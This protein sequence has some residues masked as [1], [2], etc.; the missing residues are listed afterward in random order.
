MSKQYD[1]YILASTTQVLYVGVTGDLITRI[2]QHRAKK[3]P[4]FTGRYNCTH[5]VFHETFS[6]V[7]QALERE[8]QVKGWRREKKIAL[9]ESQNPKWRHLYQDWL[10]ERSKARPPVEIPQ[11]ASAPIGMT[12][13]RVAPDDNLRPVTLSNPNHPLRRSLG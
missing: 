1:V 11:V 12:S 5:L 10:D 3:V 13:D 9:I 7:N 8:K 6:N 2:G 4:G